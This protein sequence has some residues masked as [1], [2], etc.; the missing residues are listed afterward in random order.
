M[1][2]KTA[3][4]RRSRFYMKGEFQFDLLDGKRAEYKVMDAL[5]AKGH[6][7]EDLSDDA[8]ARA[9]D[10]DCAIS[11][12]GNS[13]TLEVKNDMMSEKTGNLYI[14]CFCKKNP[15]HNFEGWFN[16][17]EAEHIA[18]VQ[19][20]AGSAHII[21]FEDLKKIVNDYRD[22]RVDSKYGSSGYL[23]PVK[24]LPKLKSYYCLQLN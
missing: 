14:E 11:K 21:T 24:E 18:F 15:G 8:A 16:Y 12:N 17:C 3:A 7:V 10:I 19:E 4:N 1:S 2:G 20:T 22:R 5:R 9:K 23:V 6:T 13:T